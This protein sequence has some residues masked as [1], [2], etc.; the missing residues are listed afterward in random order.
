MA[1][2]VAAVQADDFLKMADTARGG[3]INADGRAQFLFTNASFVDQ[4]HGDY[5][6][7]NWPLRLSVTVIAVG[8]QAC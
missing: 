3:N 8:G 1:P 4:Q 7:L 2:F 6:A 5:T